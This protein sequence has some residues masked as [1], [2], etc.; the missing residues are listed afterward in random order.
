MTRHRGIAS[1]PRPALSTGRPRRLDQVANPFGPS[2]QVF[3]ALTTAD[4]LLHLNDNDV[5]RLGQRLASHAGIDADQLVLANGMDELLD[6]IL[7]WRRHRGPVVLFP[8][9]DPSHRA[10]VERHS[11][12]ILEYRR[13]SSFAAFDPLASQVPDIPAGSTAIV[14][15][16]N[17]PSGTLLST[18][19]AVRL[20]RVCELVVVDER[21]GE[22][23]ARS[24]L[25]VA[26]EFNNVIVARSFETWAGLSGL[27]FAYA[28]APRR[29][30]GELRGYLRPS[31]IAAAAA[32][33]VAATLDDMAYMQA[34]VRRVRQERT[35]L[36]RTLRKLNMV[37]VPYPT[38]SN[39]I[40]TRIER[41]DAGFFARELER[42]GIMVHR[43][44]D[45][46]LTERHLRITATT[47]E[48]TEAL[49]R[50]LIEIA[51]AEL[52]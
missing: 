50:A 6:M 46:Q 20:A 30:A 8:P 43:P 16:P 42:R 51:A 33:A 23:A 38:S 14:Q 31:G 24:L 37:R 22:Y 27:P 21:H 35:R 41:G 36:W 52:N 4:R 40:L 28:V 25:P 48:Q 15:S 47:P 1:S 11:E 17:D 29:L 39:F 5:Q 44:S 3:E 19:D 32:V 13:T 18:P 7:L 9:T 12:D 10:I 2:A 45:P 26:Q 34:T 49:K